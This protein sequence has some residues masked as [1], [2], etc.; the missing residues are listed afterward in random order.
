MFRKILL[1]TIAL[2]VAGHTF[3]QIKKKIK[4]S[5]RNKSQSQYTLD[6]NEFQYEWEAGYETFNKTLQTA[7]YPN[8]VFH[9]GISKRMEV[10]SE[11]TLL[12][13]IDK[14]QAVRKNTS[15]I[16]PIGFGMNYLLV[17]ESPLH[18]AVIGSLQLAIPFL[19]T[20]NFVASHLAPIMQLNIRQPFSKK[21]TIG[22]APG[23]FWD[24]F[25]TNPSYL[26]NLDTDYNPS[27]NWQISPE[28]FGFISNNSAPQHNIDLEVDHKFSDKIQFGIII[29]KGLSPAAHKSYFAITGVYDLHPHHN[30][31]NATPTDLN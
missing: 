25:S 7:T 12:T 28:I 5:R 10:N 1:L 23:F 27:D 24:G 6:K 31:N 16:E 2:L 29:G 17:K 18:P 21:L 3:S 20:R 14:T 9:Y 19:A 30:K 22:I 15:G 8:M 26:Y 11:A 13:A 4:K